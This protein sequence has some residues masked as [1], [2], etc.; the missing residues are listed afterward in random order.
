MKCGDEDLEYSIKVSLSQELNRLMEMS[1]DIVQHKDSRIELLLNRE[2]VYK[3][4]IKALQ[5]QLEQATQNSAHLSKELE[6]SNLRKRSLSKELLEIRADLEAAKNELKLV[7]NESE[8]D[9]SHLRQELKEE[10]NKLRV[11]EIGHSLLKRESDE[12]KA[13]LKKELEEA[14]TNLERARAE[15]KVLKNESGEEKTNLEKELTETKA[16]LEELILQKSES[17]E[18]ML[19]KLTLRESKSEKER[20]SLEQE[21]M[22]KEKI[23]ESLARKSQIKSESINN[24]QK[25][26][27]A[28]SAEKEKTS[29]EL[30]LS[31]IK[32]AS[33]KQEQESQLKIIAEQ[34]SKIKRFS[35][36]EDW[37]NLKTEEKSQKLK[38]LIQENEA[39]LLDSE[40]EL[41]LLKTE[42]NS[43][44]EMISSFKEEV[45]TLQ[46]ILDGSK[47]KTLK[48]KD[49]E[50][51][52]LYKEIEYMNITI[53]L[54]EMHTETNDEQE[55]K[56]EISDYELKML[57]EQFA[58]LSPVREDVKVDVDVTIIDHMSDEEKE[59]EIKEEEVKKD[60]NSG[61]SQ[62]STSKHCS[63]GRSLKRQWDVSFEEKKAEEQEMR[64]TENKKE[65]DR[66]NKWKFGKK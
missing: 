40:N 33:S 21:I 18:K 55:N 37:F 52:L 13:S 38:T 9:M 43:L 32:L 58:S 25:Q 29:K 8:Q 42:K 31:K 41:E 50:V 39:K 20:V 65:M 66:K 5:S 56:V 17:E 63:W 7:K 22:T 51:S 27:C 44:S 34:Q 24:L 26:H 12:E 28:L 35:E 14:I 2:N 1:K 46:T 19:S 54:M 23:I 57:K 6:N 30:V 15:L 64:S 47:L 11:A 10:N 62:S 36:N 60:D 48:N 59:G 49:R 4:E 3:A 53:Q 45:T 61:D 16:S